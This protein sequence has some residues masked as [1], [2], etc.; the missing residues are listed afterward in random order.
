MPY[1]AWDPFLTQRGFAALRA[2][3][4]RWL[5]CDTSLRAKW[6]LRRTRRRKKRIGA[7][8]RPPSREL[9]E[10]FNSTGAGATPRLLYYFGLLSFCT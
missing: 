10:T 2:L 9:C 8:S 1:R 6:F 4:S 7:F 3:S 5:V